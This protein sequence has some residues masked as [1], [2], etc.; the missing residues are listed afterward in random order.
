MLKNYMEDS[1]SFYLK[2]ILSDN[3]QYNDV[4]KCDDCISAIEADALN[5]LRTFYIT[6]KEGEVYGEYSN[7]EQQE[8]ADIMQM[9]TLAIEKVRGRGHD[10]VLSDA[11]QL[12]AAGERQADA[13]QMFLHSVAAEEL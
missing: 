3:K 2:R 5:H 10:G 13:L 8:I 9:L 12:K 7:R 4:C 11:A 1:V 6:T